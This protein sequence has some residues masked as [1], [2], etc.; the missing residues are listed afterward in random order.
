MHDIVRN[1]PRRSHSRTWKVRLTGLLFYAAT[2]AWCAYQ[3][4]DSLPFVV[5]GAVLGGGYL[6]VGRA[7]PWWGALVFAAV[8][9]LV[10]LLLWPSLLTGTYSDLRD[11]R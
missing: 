5:P 11:G 8:V 3:F 2:V 4:P 1:Q 10:P 7:K 6:H 9:I